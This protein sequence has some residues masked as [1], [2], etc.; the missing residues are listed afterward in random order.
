[1]AITHDIN[2]AAQY[3]DDVLLLGSETDYHKGSTAEVFSR[4][5]L[6]KVF[7]VSGYSGRVG[8]ENFFL[9]LGKFAKDSPD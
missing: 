3:C 7:G 6:E 5:N 9:P 2:L 4:Q 8:K 1:M